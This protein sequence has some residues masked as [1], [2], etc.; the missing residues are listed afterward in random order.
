VAVKAWSVVEPLTRIVETLA[1]VDE[2]VERKPFKKAR[3]VEVAFSAEPRVLNGKAKDE[4]DAGQAVL[5]SLEIQRVVKAPVEEKKLV[6]VALDAVK[7]W[8]VE[9]PRA[10]KFV[11][12]SCVA[13]ADGENRAWKVEDP[14]TNRL[15]RVSN[16]T[17]EVLALKL[18]VEAKPET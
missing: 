9:E 12:Y 15:T 10:R 3:V 13:V 2:A 1:S 7:S 5:Q 17:L 6:V 16:P 11:A 18:V 14:F 8:S 4:P